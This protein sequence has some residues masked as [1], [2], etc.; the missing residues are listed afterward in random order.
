MG[1]GDM[2]K[3]YKI[4]FV[5]SIYFI[6]VVLLAVFQL[7]T[8]YATVKGLMSQQGLVIIIIVTGLSQLILYYVSRISVTI[9]DEIIVIKTPYRTDHAIISNI[10]KMER[11]VSWGTTIFCITVKGV[12]NDTVIGFPDAVK[13]YNEILSY[14]EQRT[15]VKVKWGL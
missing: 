10:T 8:I 2:K 15:G 12:K 5:T 3:I 4:E 11:I 9:D 1:L 7:Y 14:I 6:F 13:G